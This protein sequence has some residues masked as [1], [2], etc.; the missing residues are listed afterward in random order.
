MSLIAEDFLAYPCAL[1]SYLQDRIA[2][3][4]L[5]IFAILR[6]LIMAEGSARKWLTLTVCAYSLCESY[7]RGKKLLL[8]EAFLLFVMLDDYP[9]Q[10]PREQRSLRW[11]QPFPRTAFTRLAS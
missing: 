2:Y 3:R 9:A 6:L 8:L 11:E 5:K 1:C 4:P 7:F 10:V